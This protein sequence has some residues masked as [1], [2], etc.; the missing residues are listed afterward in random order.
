[1]VVADDDGPAARGGAARQPGWC[2]SA[3]PTSSPRST[4]ARCSTDLVRGLRGPRRLARGRADAPPTASARRSAAGRGAARRR[5]RRGARRAARPGTTQV[6]WVDR[7]PT[8][9][10]R[11][12]RTALPAALAVRDAAAAGDGPRRARGA[13]P[14]PA[15]VRPPRGPVRRTPLEPAG[16][17]L[18]RPRRPA[19]RST[20]RYVGRPLLV[21]ANDYALGV[22][23]G[24]TGVVVATGRR[25]P[26]C[27]RRRPAPARSTSPR[28]GSATSRP[29]TR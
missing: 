7:R 8:R 1:M 14:A 18:A 23:N 17:A 22:Y 27:G 5:R 4:P 10:P 24:D 16:R 13:R 28:R 25:R 11:S 19:T 26:A 12:G 15:A 9:P 29:C 3:T 21:T 2:W 20:S 6:E